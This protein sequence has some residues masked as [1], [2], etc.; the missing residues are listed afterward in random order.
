M[1]LY[2]LPVLLLFVSGAIQFSHAACTGNSLGN[3]DALVPQNCAIERVAIG[4]NLT[5]AT[6][7]DLGRTSF[8]RLPVPFVHDGGIPEFLPST[9]TATAIAGSPTD[10]GSSISEVDCEGRVTAFF[11]TSGQKS[12]RVEVFQL[13]FSRSATSSNALLVTVD[14]LAPSLQPQQVFEAPQPNLNPLSYSAGT[15]Y[16]TSNDIFVTGRIVDPAP[17]VP[18][19]QLS[20]QVVGGL[21]DPGQIQANTGELPGQFG[22]ALGLENESVDGEYFVELA[23]W[24]TANADGN[25]DD[26]SPAN[27]SDPVIY[28]VV[29]DT[30]APVMTKLEVIRNSNTATQ[31]IEE[32]PGVY[33][34]RETIQIRATF[35]EDL[36]VAP[37]LT[38]IQQGSGVGNPP[39]QYFAIH[40][41]VLFA[42]SPN[43]VVYS[44]TPQA[45]IKDI[46]PVDFLFEGGMDRAGN[47]LSDSDGVLIN[48]AT[49]TRALVIDTIPP[50]L[51]RVQADSI[52]VIQSKPSNNETLPKGAFPSEIVVIV[53]DYDLPDS[54]PEDS[55]GDVFGR[56]NASGVDFD[57]VVDGGTQTSSEVISVTFT[58]PDGKSLPG[59][60][61]T[62]P[63]NGLVFILSP[64]D[65]LFSEYPN[66]QAPEGL[67]SI[68]VSLVDKVGNFTVERFSFNVDNTDV[69]PESI[70][71]TLIPFET[72]ENFQADDGNPLLSKPITGIQIPDSRLFF[73]DLEE[74]DSVRELTDI[75]LCSHD[76]TF[77][78]TRSE[79]LFKARLNGPDTIAR[80][81]NTTISV[82]IDADNGTCESRG[83][84]TL[85]P[86]D[87]SNV[88]PVVDVEWPNPSSVGSEVIEGQRDPRF[89]LYDGPYLV[90]VT[91]RDSAGNI[92]DP[93][94]K[95]FLFDTTPP[96]TRLIFPE[97]FSKINTPLRHFSAII[98]DPHPPKLHVWEE[99]GHLN[100]GSGISKDYSGMS[101]KLQLA[102]RPEDLD[103]SLFD[104]ANDNNIK[105]RLSYV[106]RPNSFDATLPSYRSEDDFYRLL[107]E[108]IDEF[109]N[110]RTLPQDG[111]ADGIYEIEV[112]PVDNA[113]N[114]IDG[115]LAG[116]SGWKPSS[117]PDIDGPQELRKK[118]FFL[119]DTIPPN[120]VIDDWTSKSNG[121]K[122]VVAG[123]EFNLTGK[124]KDLSARRDFPGRG[125][126]GM[127]QVDWEIVLL[128]P[129][130]SLAE[131][132][133]AEG[134]GNTESL[135]SNPVLTGLA[136]LAAIEDPSKDPTVDSTR[137]LVA[138][139]YINLE[140]EERV[141]RID[142]SLPSM[143]K[144]IGPD[145]VE[146]GVLTKYFLRV[147]AKDMAG[148]QSMQSIEMV[149]NQGTL[150]APQ[151]VSPLVNQYVSSTAVSFEW[152]SVTNAVDYILYISTPQGTVQTHAVVPR[153]SEDK[154]VESL[155]IL[156]T[157]GQYRWWVRARDSAGAEGILSLEQVFTIDTRAPQ[158]NL[159][160]W[161]DISPDTIPTITRG[162]FLLKIR[163][164][165]DLSDGPFVQY[166]PFLGSIPKQLIQTHRLIDN[167]WEGYVEIPQE[168]DSQWNGQ[169]I[170]HVE[171]AKDLAGNEML[172]DKTRYFEIETGPTFTL[173]F[174]ENPVNN[175]EL[176]LL[177]KSSEVLISDPI[178]STPQ[179][180]EVLNIHPVKITESVYSTSLKLMESAVDT[181]GQLTISGQDLLGNAA[182]RVVTFAIGSIEG[183]SGGSISNA[184]LNLK[185][186]EGSFQ[187]QR[188]FALL[189]VAENS[190]ESLGSEVPRALLKS[191]QI[192]DFGTIF[193]TELELIKPAV[194]KLKL[195]LSIPSKSGLFLGSVSGLEFVTGVSS[196]DSGQWHE[197]ELNSLGS[198]HLARDLKPPKLI[199]PDDLSN[200]S[201]E[202]RNFSIHVGL[203]D[204]LSG[205]DYSSIKAAVGSRKLQITTQNEFVILKNS[206]PLPEGEQ[207]LI[208][209]ASDLVG[210]AAIQKAV[211]RVLG[212]LKMHFSSY[213]NPARRMATLEYRLNQSVA[214]VQLRIYDSASKLVFKSRSVEDVNL[215]L[216]SGT[217]RFDWYLENQQGISVANG[218]YMA[219]LSVK[220][221]S[222]ISHK[223]RCKIAVIR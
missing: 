218:V 134:E 99:D 174:F 51:N 87:Q 74:L 30:A 36:K 20:V 48:G 157:N 144:I 35:S 104:I 206:A 64:E 47:V 129:D 24:D 136:Q 29:K 186:L 208:L 31:T 39:D 159:V 132:S 22:I 21:A 27:R 107:L 192:F 201:F 165:G 112:L 90:E 83:I 40:D 143:A 172:P 45:G 178:I 145:D 147:Y 4:D 219:Q 52:G 194:V 207:D 97:N 156:N 7:L 148:N 141:W 19:D 89:G 81:M 80:T 182:S 214:D 9:F 56:S 183:G 86:G 79:A 188:N 193:P 215:P 119:M 111:S 222:G 187:G 73:R 32:V 71:V 6:D 100:F 41:Q 2:L 76:P 1:K 53:K 72:N 118:F 60:L 177:I 176:T 12:I 166:Q 158:I 138:S 151:L 63:P 67:Y 209:E 114:S 92:S 200:K 14:Q 202:G 109:G 146:Q 10:A 128:N 173:K 75:E 211:I 46:G 160:T 68:E 102:Y 167:L 23:A 34:K 205:I 181:V 42:A 169:A 199:L 139:D 70:Q 69:R 135:K 13:V 216:F 15:T 164:D 116:N 88:F 91:A 95:E 108:F 152:E 59:T 137:P 221:Q 8:S 180:I 171:N 11:N 130:G 142:G 105:G 50:D 18:S 28:K 113:G 122:I 16:F 25:F 96:Y 103:S 54:L 162:K 149:I 58:A 189:P 198:L 153:A 161:T 168:A 184:I 220:D 154:N 223:L 61:S 43:Q 62:K 65:V 93:I 3:C 126:A 204:E 77:N 127:K 44:L 155:H 185:L 110:T 85:T 179:N 33:V 37:R 82:E 123:G 140:L 120:L 66:R 117:N 101:A 17:S 125:G 38:I 190:L 121:S 26:G 124:C 133:S 170:L 196:K 212:E 217:H 78:L 98:E 57:R 203:T 49:I 150:N 213:P 210:N 131:L 175:S 191:P 197:I 163:F 5:D 106:H 55:G 195:P 84:I 94:I 115:A